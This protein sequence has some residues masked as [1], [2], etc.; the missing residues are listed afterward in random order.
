MW[1]LG[2]GVSIIQSI[3]YR[4]HQHCNI[5]QKN[6]G[7]D[8]QFW[9][10]GTPLANYSLKSRSGKSKLC[11]PTYVGGKQFL[12]KRG[13]YFICNMADVS[14]RE[15]C[16]DIHLFL[17]WTLLSLKF[18]LLCLARWTATFLG[19]GWITL[20]YFMEQ[21]TFLTRKI[22]CDGVTLVFQKTY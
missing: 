7:T 10:R 19:L 13:Y 12:L 11:F 9:Y 17:P 1:V 2:E 21:T 6:D 3:A 15:S 22:K 5:S 16:N 8:Q 20:S 18:F 4:K 14:H